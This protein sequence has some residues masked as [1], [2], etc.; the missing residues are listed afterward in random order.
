MYY[1]IGGAGVPNFGDELIVRQWLDFL[2]GKIDEKIVVSGM[3]KKALINIFQEKY[4]YVHYS[5]ALY[6]YQSKLPSGFWTSLKAGLNFFNDGIELEEG[7]KDRLLSS[8]VFHLHGGGY[9]NKLW[10]NNAFYI[11]LGAALKE[12]TGCRVVGTGLG[13]MPS[14]KLDESV[15]AVYKEALMAF[16][17]IEVRDY[18]SFE[19]IQKAS[20]GQ[21]NVILGL[22]D[23]FLM[24]PSLQA[25]PKTIHIIIHSQSWADAAVSNLDFD[26][27]NSFERK[28]FWQCHYKDVDRYNELEKKIPNLQRLDVSE[29]THE[30]LPMGPED[31]M[32]TSRF[33]PHMQAARS[34]LRGQ[35]I[36]PFGYSTTKHFSVL[37]LGS[38][39]S[40]LPESHADGSYRMYLE[41][42][43]RTIKKQEFWWEKVGNYL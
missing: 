35:Y 7:E 8:K 40:P 14:P 5:S 1:L 18:P 23:I 41:D 3:R 2:A 10:P 6:S 21:A 43:G 13:L 19:Y 16:D 29:L 39:F 9:I 20:N 24:Q 31:F 42:H 25:G 11:G 36:A 26:Y 34:G 15:P 12:K 32:I 38:R 17:A 33:H 4:P 37:A 30:P 27:I 22:D 28:I